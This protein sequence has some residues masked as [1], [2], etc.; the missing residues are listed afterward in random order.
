MAKDESDDVVDLLRNL[1]T[2]KKKKKVTSKKPIEDKHSIEV[3]L[4]AE[5]IPIGL[6]LCPWAIRARNHG[7]LRCKS[8]TAR[9]VSDIEMQ[10]RVEALELCREDIPPMTTTLLVC[11]YVI[12]FE[13]FVAFDDFVKRME[14]RLM[15][16]ELDL[17][18]T[19]VSFHPKFLRWHGLPPGIKI[20]SEVRSFRA[21]A[22]IFQKSPDRF[23][24]IVVETTNPAFGLRKI[25]VRFREDG[26]EQ[27]VP[28][29]WLT[30]DDEMR[31]LPLPDNA[32]HRA[33]Y[34]TIH[35][36][37]DK[38]LGSLSA[39]DVSRVK[40]MNSLRILQLGWDGLAALKT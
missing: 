31:G 28:V 15:Q 3:S 34:P 9:K 6:G 38:D 23:P 18:V 7:N 14:K 25:K 26:A 40:R 16:L 17:E 39:R 19:L 10:L 1:L 8:S 37:R 27:Y 29:D 33:P 20:G 30:T 22:G 11:P 36:I 12:A 21:A 32:M 2:D 13:Q 24:A 35:L 5:R 4:W